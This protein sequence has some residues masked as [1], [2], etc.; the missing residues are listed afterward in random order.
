MATTD[1]A[2]PAAPQHSGGGLPGAIAAEWT[3]LWGLRST[4]LCLGIA[5]LAT[6]GTALLAALALQAGD[7]TDGMTAN[8][9]ATTAIVLSQFA[10]VAAA[11]LIVTGE[12]ATGAMR[13]T[14]T[15]VPNRIRM[16]VAKAAVLAVAVFATGC[17]AGAAAIAATAAVYGD[18][19]TFEAAH[20]VHGIVG[21]GGY[22]LGISL[23]TMGLGLLMRSTAGA[24]TTVVGVLMAIPM[25]SQMVGSETLTDV[26]NYM[27]ANAGMPL[28]AGTTDPYG[29]GTGALLMAGWAALTL[30]VGYA[31]MAKR[32]A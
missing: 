2:R 5:V 1:Q 22:M 4:W 3:K 15:T 12:Y 28:M 30:A 7:S 26:V 25:V 27:P 14:L 31:A 13:T 17:A 19:M 23:F 10:V 32:D 21:V 16:L 6:G 18:A 20:V 9:L 24:I 29:W 8:A 11:S